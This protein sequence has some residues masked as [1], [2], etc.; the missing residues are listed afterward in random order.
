MSKAERRKTKMGGRMSRSRVPAEARVV[1]ISPLLAV[2]AAGGCKA[3]EIAAGPGETAS[4]AATGMFVPWSP[5]ESVWAMDFYVDGGRRW[6]AGVERGGR[7]QVWSMTRDYGLGDMLLDSEPRGFTLQ[8]C[9]WC[10]D[11]LLYGKYEGLIDLDYLEKHPP[12]EGVYE[13]C[14]QRFRSVA[15]DPETDDEQPGVPGGFRA[16][17][18]DGEGK[19][20]IAF[21][22]PYE[23]QPE[24]PDENLARIY[25]MPGLR[26]QSEPKLR[27]GGSVGTGAGSLPWLVG[28]HPQ[29]DG[30]YA[31]AQWLAPISPADPTSFPT[32]L[33]VFV[34]A[35]GEIE[36]LTGPE[37]P[38]LRKT[39][40]GEV[41]AVT[42][43]MERTAVAAMIQHWGGN[44][45]IAV[46]DRHGLLREYLFSVRA[47]FPPKLAEVSPWWRFIAC[48]PDGRHA[49]FQETRDQNNPDDDRNGSWWV[50]LWD[51]EKETH[52]PIVQMNEITNCFGWLSDTALV[53]GARAERLPPEA[54]NDELRDY[55]VLHLT[56]PEAKA[57]PGAD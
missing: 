42:P 43:V 36:Q 20:L 9:A 3:G 39:G 6:L 52:Q 13:Y 15:W 53:V 24:R 49:L 29:E 27:F 12:P 21:N 30:F 11:K 18:G 16:A 41:P 34:D 31:V 1:L 17:A 44:T 40:A 5:Y 23:E 56:D 51:L 2:C 19:H 38:R 26:L 7:V 46:Y 32:A 45:G 8:R 48:A 14:A 10:G 54:S 4:Q 35:D 22:P 50:C 25:Q 28:W 57:E 47:S 55:G 33:L 37:E